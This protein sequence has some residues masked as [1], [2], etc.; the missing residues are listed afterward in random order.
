MARA[1]RCPGSRAVS[2]AN[3]KR[4]A[5]SRMNTMT[6]CWRRWI[7][8]GR[9]EKWIARLRGC[10][11]RD[12]D[13]HGAARI[14]GGICSRF[15]HA[16]ARNSCGAAMP[17]RR[18]RRPDP[19]KPVAALEAGATHAH[20]ENRSRFFTISRGVRLAGN[21]AGDSARSRLRQR[22]ARHDLHAFAR[23]GARRPAGERVLDLGT[24]SGIWRWRRGVSA[25]RKSWRPI[26]IPAAVRTARAK[27]GA[28]FFHAADPLAP[29]GR[30]EAVARK[31]ATILCWRIFSAESWSRRRR[32]CPP[33]LPR[34][35]SFGSS[36][37]LLGQQ[38]EVVAAY[39]GTRTAA[40][41]RDATRK[42]GDAA[43]AA[44]AAARWAAVGEA[45]SA[46]LYV[47]EDGLST[48]TQTKYP[49]PAMASSTQEGEDIGPCFAI[50]AP[51]A[52]LPTGEA[53]A[54]SGGRPC[55]AHSARLT[56][57]EGFGIGWPGGCVLGIV[58]QLDV[59]EAQDVVA[60][61]LLLRDA[62]AVD[63]GAVGRVEVLDDVI[64]LRRA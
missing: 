9:Q 24:G 20:R 26:S 2:R 56:R 10:G 59:A 55:E 40:D 23:P 41:P 25:R 5:N 39:R 1:A 28:Q 35:G 44:V 42:M 43:V 53:L 30:E 17:F 13:A 37:I 61:K 50:L 60:A 19:A 15:T 38:D 51:W 52:R 6:W 31:S 57:S 49:T 62:L 4:P 48:T 63:A 8:P 7:A 14:A 21:R 54:K 16:Q 47:G 64:E 27:R 45:A 11:L 18:P 33:A 29:R 3:R 12:M 34:A 22:R 32:N 58:K 46:L 36:G